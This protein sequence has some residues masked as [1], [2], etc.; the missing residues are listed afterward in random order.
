MEKWIKNQ[1]FERVAQSLNIDKEILIKDVN[2]Y[3]R[4]EMT[5]RCFL[6]MNRAINLARRGKPFDDM[7]LDAYKYYTAIC[8]NKIL[9]DDIRATLRDLY[10][11]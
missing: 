11:G 7:L 8:K 3:I 2:T 6:K 1:I 9:L 10:R 5:R 4:F